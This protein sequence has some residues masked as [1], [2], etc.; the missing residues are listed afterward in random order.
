MSGFS[1]AIDGP[2]AAGKSTCAKSLAEKLGLTYINTGSMYRALTL[3]SIE[4]EVDPEDE[5]GLVDLL[6][7]HEIKVDGNFAAIDDRDVSN[8]I[9]NDAVTNRVSIVCAHA[10]VRELL[11]DMQRK[12]AAG[13][14][15]VME[16]RDIGT[17][18]L[19]RADVKIFMTASP[20]ERAMRRKN[21]PKNPELKNVSIDEIASE[22]ARRDRLD[23][24]REV[25]PLK[26][27]ED[28]ITLDTTGQDIERVVDDLIRIIDKKR[29]R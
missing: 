12:M 10:D 24:E 13:N 5:A 19:P 4:H 1:V 6:R 14:S 29:I 27:A 9:R 28:A 8:E 18:V 15:V 3:L 25:A 17:V 11:V 2:A 20:R 16:G 22:I 21:D 23:S 26:V 7:K